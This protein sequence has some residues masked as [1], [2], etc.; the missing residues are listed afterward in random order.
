M[1]DDNWD[2]L[3][4]AKMVNTGLQFARKVQITKS[5]KLPEKDTEAKEIHCVKT[6]NTGPRKRGL[7]SL[8]LLG[9]RPMNIVA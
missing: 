5:K 2:C 7:H 6:K 1:T 8:V 4:D 3:Q 9:A